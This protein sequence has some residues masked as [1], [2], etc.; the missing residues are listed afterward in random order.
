MY[1]LKN[2]KG[3]HIKIDE[4]AEYAAE[5]LQNKVWEKDRTEKKL[6]LKLKKKKKMTGILKINQR[7]Q[8]KLQK[9]ILRLMKLIG[10][11]LQ[12]NLD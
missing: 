3:E 9:K 11:R 8:K 6:Q 2:E 1:H 7:L 4:I 10:M 5:H 12:N